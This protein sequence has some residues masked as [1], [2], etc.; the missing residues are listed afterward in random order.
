MRMVRSC[1][2]GVLGTLAFTLA[3]NAC[4]LS[5]SWATSPLRYSISS[6]VPMTL[7]ERTNGD[8]GKKER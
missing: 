2:A 7:D 1:W 8:E 6:G 5:L 4:I 3:S